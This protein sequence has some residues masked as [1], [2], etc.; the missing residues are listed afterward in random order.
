MSIQEKVKT[1]KP[2]IGFLTY[3]WEISSR[4]VL[5]SASSWYRCYLPMIELIKNGYSVGMSMPSISYKNE[6]EILVPNKKNNDKLDIVVL[7]LVNLKHFIEYTKKA[8]K[9]G[10]K[11]VVDIDDY[12]GNNVYQDKII[13]LTTALIVS[14]PFLQD[15]Y[16]KRYPNKP[17]FLVR[18]GINLDVWKNKNN[19]IENIPTFGWV[20][21]TPHRVKDLNELNPF[22]GDFIKKNKYKFHH[23]GT[24]DKA[25]SADKLIGL[26]KGIFTHETKVP[27]S[28]YPNL[29]KKIDIGLVPLSKSFINDAKSFIRGL[30]FTGAGIPFIASPSLEY[31]YLAEQ[32][33]G[34]VAN[35]PDEW[36]R[37]AKE[38]LDPSVRKEEVKKNIKN[39]KEK[40]SMDVVVGDWKNAFDTIH[41]I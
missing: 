31:S 4:P 8:L 30:E 14:T 36:L 6:Y 20:G 16:Q 15:F 32:G 34:R 10:Q 12:P 29:F 25:P 21:A 26:D 23:S 3:D 13:D 22:F 17:I 7:K 35:S 19:H 38:L 41:K 24:V 11:I 9:T 33:V 1:I 28:L 18:N 37:H 5:P 40:F 2:T 39:V 27:I